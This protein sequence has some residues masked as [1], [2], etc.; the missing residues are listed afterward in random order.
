MAAAISGLMAEGPGS[1]VPSMGLTGMLWNRMD[2]RGT[3]ITVGV[4]DLTIMSLLNNNGSF[5]C[6]VDPG[7]GMD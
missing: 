4:A 2:H 5:G 7:Y 1:V 3:W 6:I